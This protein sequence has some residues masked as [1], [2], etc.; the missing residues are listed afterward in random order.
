M[1]ELI[2]NCGA[3]FPNAKS[4]DQYHDILAKQGF[5]VGYDTELKV[6]VTPAHDIPVYVQNPPP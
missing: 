3:G 5:D 2:T 4:S 6:K 1:V